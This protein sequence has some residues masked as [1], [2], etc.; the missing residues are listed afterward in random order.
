MVARMQAEPAA[1]IDGARSKATVQVSSAAR[2]EHKAAPAER[3]MF[4]LLKRLWVHISFKRRWQ[5]AILLILM[6]IASVAEIVSIGAVVPFLGVLTSPEMIFKHRLTQPLI[7]A[8]GLQQPRDLLLPLTVAFTAA[9][10]ISGGMRLVMLYVQTRLSHSIGTDFSLG[11][12]RRWIYQPY[13]VQTTRNSSEIISAVTTKVVSVVH[14]T[15]LP[16]MS[17]LSSILI[18]VAI[19]ATLFAIEPGTTLV[20]VL[21]FGGIYGAIIVTTR[22]RLAR[23][24][25][26][27][28]LEQN[29][30]IK[31]LQ[32]GLGGIRDVLIDGTQDAH[33]KIYESADRPMRHSLSTIQI[34]AGTPRFA[35]EALGMVFIALIAYWLASGP[36]GLIGSISSLGA[37]ALGAQRMLPI[38]QL[39]FASW[40]S[41]RGGQAALRDVL[42]LLD[43]PL[44]P[45]AGQPMPAPIPFRHDIRLNGLSFRYAADAP[46]VL[47]DIDLRIPKGSRI[48]FIGET[49]SGKSTMLDVIMGLLPPTDGTLEIDGQA[50][51]AGNCRAWQA[52]LAHV[53]QVIFLADCTIAENIAFGVP[54]DRIDFDRVRRAARQAQI[55]ETIESWED[56]YDTVVGERG[57]RISGGQRQRLGIA[58]ALYKASDVIVFDEATSALDNST[59]EAVMQA[60]ES[61]GDDVTVMI[62]A[63]RLSTLRKCDQV[64]ELRDGRIGR[65]GSY[66]EIVEAASAPNTHQI[67]RTTERR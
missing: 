63:H 2:S 18:M 44:P 54:K 8:L 61:L 28:A 25:K 50:V 37:L 17:I 29:R 16:V 55:A 49:G 59:E 14:H 58:R 20:A 33:V 5:F 57:V 67:Q 22:R 15:L 21:G 6:I 38:L 35:I 34:I 40:S 47:K 26:R 42:D 24:G 64:V 13:L 56:Q 43:Q 48:G 23:D 52:H 9:A 65:L 36:D 1:V 27:V 41:L 53:P 45:Y 4:S 12:Y 31:A 19:L 7:Q 46:Y 30:A 10:L 39:C 32:E 11:I 66:E 62:V 60:I 51:T 3:S